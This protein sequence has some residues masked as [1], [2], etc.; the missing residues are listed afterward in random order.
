MLNFEK[1]FMFEK[2]KKW[3]IGVKNKL[4][5]ILPSLEHCMWIELQ[6]VTPAVCRRDD[7]TARMN[8]PQSYPSI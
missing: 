7:V 5:I 4:T 6:P 8:I 2:V 3:D 1:R